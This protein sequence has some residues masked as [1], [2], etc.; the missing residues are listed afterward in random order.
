MRYAYVSGQT[1]ENTYIEAISA[2]DKTMKN[3][4]VYDKQR[5]QKIPADPPAVKPWEFDLQACQSGADSNKP[6]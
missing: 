6:V 2:N 4:P 5:D 1:V 3:C